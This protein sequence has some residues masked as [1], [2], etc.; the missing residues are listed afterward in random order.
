MIIY[1]FG[2]RCDVKLYIEYLVTHIHNL[3]PA[4]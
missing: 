2:R 4:I 3:D 1:R